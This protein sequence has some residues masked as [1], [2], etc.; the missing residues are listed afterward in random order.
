MKTISVTGAAGGIDK[1]IC[2]VFYQA[3][4]RVISV[5]R[6]LTDTPML[7]A[8][9]GENVEGLEQLGNYHPLKHIAEPEEVAQI[10]LF[11]ASPQSSFMT[12]AAVN[13]DGGIGAC[14]HDPV[15]AR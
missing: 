3:D 6:H 10:V 4:Y 12:G 2:D 9:F 5:D 13:V 7:R 11:L 14:L 1:A 8:S 15:V